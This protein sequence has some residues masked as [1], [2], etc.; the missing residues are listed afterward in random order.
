KFKYLHLFLVIVSFSC[1]EK[2]NDSDT[3][4]IVFAKEILKVIDE[5]KHYHPN[6]LDSTFNIPYESGETWITFKR[7]NGTLDSTLLEQYKSGLPKTE[8]NF[9]LGSLSFGEHGSYYDTLIVYYFATKTDTMRMEMP[10]YKWYYNSNPN[11]ELVYQRNYD[12]LGDPTNSKGDLIEYT[13]HANQSDS[14]VIHFYLVRE[15][16]FARYYDLHRKFY[17]TISGTEINNE[18]IEIN[19][20]YSAVFY[21]LSQSELKGK[22]VTGIA[23]YTDVV[24]KTDLTTTRTDTVILHF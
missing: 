5:A 15:P 9:N 19:E 16:Y 23:E 18:E 12:S 7:T 8:I 4:S 14:I 21:K 22:Q 2:N 17:L 1:Q 6:I 13:K 10:M 20:K 24:D 3:D 11:G